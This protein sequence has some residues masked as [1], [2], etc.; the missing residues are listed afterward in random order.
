VQGRLRARKRVDPLTGEVIVPGSTE[1][2]ARGPHRAGPRNHLAL[3]HGFYARYLP[4]FEWLAEEGIELDLIDQIILRW[5]IVMQRIMIV[6]YD[7]QTLQDALYYLKI[8]GWASVRLVKAIKLK[9][10]LRDLEIK[11][12]WEEFFRRK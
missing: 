12:Q 2:P 1:I 3:T 8:I 4:E 5:R 9:Q 10:E 6:G 7:V 11:M